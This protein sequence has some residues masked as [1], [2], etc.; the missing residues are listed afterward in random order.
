MIPF[1]YTAKDGSR[2]T[3][4]QFE[5]M[6]DDEAFELCCKGISEGDCND[7][8]QSVHT[9]PIE[10]MAY[11]L[12]FKNTGGVY[13]SCKFCNRQQCKGCLVPYTNDETM[14]DLLNNFGLNRNDTLFSDM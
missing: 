7:R 4:A 2:I 1:P 9:F 10:R 13:M 14:N 3:K 6:S 8:S 12:E 11:Q 5:A